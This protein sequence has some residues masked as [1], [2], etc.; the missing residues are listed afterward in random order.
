MAFRAQGSDNGYG[1]EENSELSMISMMTGLPLREHDMVEYVSS[2]GQG[3]RDAPQC[4]VPSLRSEEK[5]P[6]PWACVGAR[7]LPEKAPQGGPENGPETYPMLSAE[8]RSP[9][10]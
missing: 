4:G 5:R 2:H 6:R 9:P 8:F 1:S 3:K 10:N 7:N